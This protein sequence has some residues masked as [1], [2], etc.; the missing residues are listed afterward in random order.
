[1]KRRGVI[2]HRAARARRARRVRGIRSVPA[3]CRTRATSGHR[4]CCCSTRSGWLVVARAVRGRARGRASRSART[5]AIEGDRVLRHDGAAIL[6]H[7]THGLGTAVLLVTRHRARVPVRP[8]AGRRTGSRWGRHEHPLRGRRVLPVRH[9]LLRPTR[10][11]PPSASRSTCRRGTRSRTRCSTTVCCSA[12][13]SSRCRRRTS[14]SSPRRWRSSWR[15]PRP[16]LIILTGLLKVAAHVVRR[17][18]RA[19]GGRQR[20]ARHRDAAHARLLPRAR[21]LRGDPADLAGRCC[22]RCSP[23]T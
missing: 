6:A 9:L 23:A 20:H 18:R 22:A 11:W 7:W 19:H 12:S 4:T 5:R 8:A 17:A 15:S 14:T 3:A 13:R 16:A 21:L 2:A 10:C 1:M